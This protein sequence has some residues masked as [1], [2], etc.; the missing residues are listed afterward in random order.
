MGTNQNLDYAYKV[1]FLDLPRQVVSP[2]KPRED[3]GTYWGYKVRYASNIS[4]VFSDCPYKGGYD[5]LIGTS[6]HGIVVKSSQL[7]LPAFRH[8]LIA[9]GGL[10]GLEKSVEEDNKL[11]GK[12]VRDIFNMYLNTCPHQ[13]SRTIRTEEALLISLQYFQEP[14]TRAMQGPANSLKHAQA[15]VLKFMSAKMS[16]P[17]F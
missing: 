4:S 17:I 14:I 10:L 6:E 15:H 7:N 16:M 11:K 8:L 12:N 1:V 13:G 2:S 3:T 5:H 9:F